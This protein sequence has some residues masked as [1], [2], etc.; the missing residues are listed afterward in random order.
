MERTGEE[1]ERGEETRAGG[2]YHAGKGRPRRER[3][4]RGKKV[5]RGEAKVKGGTWT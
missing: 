4:G 3:G 1:S 2:R 5:F